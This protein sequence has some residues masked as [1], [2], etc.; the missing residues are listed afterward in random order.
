M[1]TPTHFK[2]LYSIENGRG[3]GKTRWVRVGTGFP[4]KIG[5]GLVLDA[6]PVNFDG[7]LLL[8]PADEE[9]PA[10]SASQPPD[11]ESTPGASQASTSGF[12]GRKRPGPLSVP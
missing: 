5:I 8:V 12:K 6:I 3:E 10:S 7:K 2:I 1:S 11:S 9:P 4:N